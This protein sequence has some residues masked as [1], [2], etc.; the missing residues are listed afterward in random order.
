MIVFVI[1]SLR[2]STSNYVPAFIS[3]LEANISLYASQAAIL[4]RTAPHDPRGQRLGGLQY[5]CGATLVEDDMLV[6]AA[7][8]VQGE[9]RITTSN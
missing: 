1:H 9:R 6:T 3:V 4:R 8:C 7:H 5:I 2:S